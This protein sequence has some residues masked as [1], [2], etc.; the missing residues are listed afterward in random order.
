MYR[1]A[2][3]ADVHLG[4]NHEPAMA[5]LELEAFEQA[6]D[7]CIERSVDFI[8]I[9]GD[10]FHTAVPSDLSIVREAVT[11]IREVKEHGIPIYVIY[12][13]HDYTPLGTSMIDV[14]EG[15]G[16]LKKVVRPRV[17]NG[18]LE[19]DYVE[20]KRTGA[21]LVGISARK[22]GLEREYYEI[23]HRESLEH[24]D[25]FTIFAFHSG[26]DEF[27][28]AYL[29]AMETM[30]LSLFPRGLSYYAGGHIHQKSD[31]RLPGYNNVVYPGPLFMGHGRGRDL[32]LTAQGEIRGFYIVSFDS[33]VTDVEF[34]ETKLIDTVYSEYD[35]SGLNSSQ[36]HKNLSEKLSDLDVGGKMVV[37]KIKGELAG[38]KTADID[39]SNLRNQLL[40]K[41]AV[42]VYLNRL[43]LTS[44][45]Y[46]AIKVAGEDRSVIEERLF[47]E[48]IGAVQIK[49][50]DLK[51]GRG[52]QLSLDLLRLLKSAKGDLENKAD[53]EARLREEAI[54]V[55][56][57]K[58]ALED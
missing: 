26:L 18:R 23:L 15:T 52:V 37:L 41:G 42:S 34:V 56:L 7:T 30:P 4:A 44:K 17:I 2:H 58:G 50:S 1:F 28:P 21:K 19:L 14:I 47:K 10:L 46:G 3:I 43:G 32:E 54:E 39:F 45:E 20:D 33:N 13:S 8:L 55:L 16:L 29:S 49:T 51:R 9:C 31:N 40:E 35:L 38:G 22:M 48:H 36:A 5:K 53:Y 25:G 27:K 24:L 6:M 11:K 57:L 12:G